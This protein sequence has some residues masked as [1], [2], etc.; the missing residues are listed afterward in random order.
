MGKLSKWGSY[1]F[2]E[3]NIKGKFHHW[4]KLELCKVAHNAKFTDNVNGN[5]Q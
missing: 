4:Q 1:P 3:A 2:I 5:V